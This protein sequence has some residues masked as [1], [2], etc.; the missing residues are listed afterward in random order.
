[1]AKAT[2]KI[3]NDTELAASSEATVE[4]IVK[5]TMGYVNVTA[6]KVEGKTDEELANWLST[7]D[8]LSRAGAYEVV[9]ITRQSVFKQTL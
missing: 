7:D 6:D 8:Y 9:K 2:K 1:M 3:S 4:Y 5:T